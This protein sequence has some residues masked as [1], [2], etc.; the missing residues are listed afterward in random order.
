MMTTAEKR[1]EDALAELREVAANYK[2]GSAFWFKE[3]REI[4]DICMAHGDIGTVEAILDHLEKSSCD[5][6][7]WPAEID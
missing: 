1:V 7:R 5:W 2:R 6:S 3:R 4:I